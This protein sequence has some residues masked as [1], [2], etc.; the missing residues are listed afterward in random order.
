[1]IES[2]LKLRFKYQ[3]IEKEMSLPE[4]VSNQKQLAKLGREYSRLG[5]LQHI[6]DEYEMILK[7]I[8]DDDYIIANETDEDFI[9]IALSE[10]DELRQKEIDLK[11]K[12]LEGLIP[13]DPNNGKNIVIEI[14]AGTGGDEA[15]LFAGDLFRMYNRLCERMSWKLEIMDLNGT[16]LGGFK[17]IVVVIEGEDAYKS[18]K[19]E[20]GVHR[21]QRVPK[22][23]ASGRIHTSAATVLAYPEAEQEDIQINEEDL[24]I[25]FYASS[26]HGGQ[27]VNRTYS[28][29]RIVHLPTGIISTCQDEKSQ[30]KN[31]DKA[32]RVL[33]ARLKQ[34][35]DEED[36]K[37]LEKARKSQVRSG[38]RS[39]KIR[40]YNF[41]QN[42]ITDH[43]INFTS[44]NLLDF[45]DGNMFDMIN[46]LNEAEVHELIENL[47]I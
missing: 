17:E 40:T 45:L 32:M 33:L 13:E 31:K 12:L 24:R 25:D 41:P 38:D 39:E 19:F 15:A 9:K 10:I 4:N 47:S 20:G 6:I 11:S 23:E 18:L 29:V 5:K 43:R 14:R 28:A 22:T 21:V 3:E 34:K 26:G 2:F 8:E 27:H 35:Q 1:M 42:R 16:D 30:H 46:A 37:L 44:Y 36:Q 7:H